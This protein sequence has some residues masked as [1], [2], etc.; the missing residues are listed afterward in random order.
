MNSYFPYKA[1]E[2]RNEWD[3]I[4]S[5][6]NIAIPILGTIC[7]YRANGGA[8][9]AAFAA[10]YFSISFV[11]GIRLLVYLTP[12]MAVV[13]GAYYWSSFVSGAT[14]QTGWFDVV[15]YSAWLGAVYA[16]IVKHIRDTTK[17]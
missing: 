10:K 5:G 17:A 8:A 4:G 3:N 15:I 1:Y 6:L 14:I 9:G 13:W 7:A 2:D 11:V 12:L 16:S